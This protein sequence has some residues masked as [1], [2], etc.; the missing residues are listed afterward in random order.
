MLSRPLK[1]IRTSAARQPCPFT[2]Q[3]RD[4]QRLQIVPVFNSLNDPR[5]FL[6]QHFSPVCTDNGARLTV[7]FSSSDRVEH[8]NRPGV[9]DLLPSLASSR[10]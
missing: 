10:G 9:I 4:P 7:L 1:H 8:V 3:G 2:L 5:R 6:Y